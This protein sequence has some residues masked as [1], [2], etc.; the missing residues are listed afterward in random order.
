[1]TPSFAE[2]LKKYWEL[3]NIALEYHEHILQHS[4]ETWLATKRARKAEKEVEKLRKQLLDNGI[5]P[6]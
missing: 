6:E 5:T 2:L 3:Y 4:A 1:M